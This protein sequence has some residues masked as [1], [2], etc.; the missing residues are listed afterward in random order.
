MNNHK[1]NL[2]GRAKTSPVY[3]MWVL[4]GQF[5]TEDDKASLVARMGKNFDEFQVEPVVNDRNDA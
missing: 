3:P 5:T 2:R 4:L 1:F